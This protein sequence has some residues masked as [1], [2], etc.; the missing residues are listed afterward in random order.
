[1]TDT[2]FKKY[3]GTKLIEAKPNLE[4]GGMDVKYPDG[5]LSWS[6]DEAFKAYQ[7]L[8][9]LS[10]GHALAALEDGYKLNRLSWNGKGLWVELFQSQGGTYKNRPLADHY[11]LANGDG[12]YIPW[13]PSPG[14]LRANDWQVIKDNSGEV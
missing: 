14:D 13:T 12:K 7:G 1:M 3:Y 9:A 6:P 10:F 5:Y 8:D 2:E 4:K 11:M